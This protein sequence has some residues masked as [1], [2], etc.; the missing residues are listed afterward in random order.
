LGEREIEGV[1]E[2]EVGGVR[3]NWECGMR[4]KKGMGR[5]VEGIE[6]MNTRLPCIV[7]WVGVNISI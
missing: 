7:R 6:K 2:W 4:N 3:W 5:G 1:V